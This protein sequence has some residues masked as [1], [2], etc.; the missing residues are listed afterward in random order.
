M[1]L[2]RTR[3]AAIMAEQRLAG[4]DGLG[5]A[6]FTLANLRRL[7]FSDR[8]L[9]GELVRDPLVAACRGGGADLATACDVLAAW[10]LR[11]DAGS[12]GA[13]LFREIWRALGG[14]TAFA[15]PFSKGDPLGTPNGLAT[16]RVDVPA[17][18]RAA[19]RTCR[20][21][22]SRSTYRWA[23]CNTSCAAGS[24]CR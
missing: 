14:P 22:A 20:P 9:S 4:T 13:V 6:G 21:R 5:P 8:N 19:V 2:P 3:L 16:D 1:N 12:R 11:A 7:F 18:I 17:A 15:T 10:D 23:T 24:G